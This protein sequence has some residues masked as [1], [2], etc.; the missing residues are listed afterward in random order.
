V[1][2]ITGHD[3]S[4]GEFWGNCGQRS[5]GVEHQDVNLVHLKRMALLASTEKEQLQ[6]RSGAVD[7]TTVN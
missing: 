2:R 1:D 3:E 4:G 7:S 5:L 6:H